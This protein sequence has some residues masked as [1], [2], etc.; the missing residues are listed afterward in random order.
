MLGLTFNYLLESRPKL[1]EFGVTV[2]LARATYFRKKLMELGNNQLYLGWIVIV[3][4]DSNEIVPVSQLL[5]TF[6]CR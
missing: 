2:Q 3:I 1:T 5:I 6:P 4:M